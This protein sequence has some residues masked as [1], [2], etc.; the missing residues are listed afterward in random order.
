M[1]SVQQHYE[2]HLAP[3]YLW[4]AGGLEHAFALGSADMAPFLDRPGLAVDLGAGFGMHSLPLAR[5]GFRVL[6]IDTSHHLLRELQ[7]HAAGLPVQAVE[8]DLLDFAAH[9]CGPAE[10]VLCMG[11]TLTHLHSPAQVAQ[12]LHTVA[13]AL[14]PGGR[15]VATFRDYHQLPKGD[16]RFIAV[17]SDALRIH[18]CFLEEQ[19]DRVQVHD[20]LHERSSE[21]VPW[22]MR[23]SSY[24][25]LRLCP[26]SMAAAARGAGLRCQ[27][28]PG[29][30]GMLQLVA[31]A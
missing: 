17:R 30:R 22:Q 2:S 20:V 4:M 25:K 5:A 26:E 24:P 6:A 13:G 10:L 29:P 7:Q 3:I 12:L 18:I 28:G 9:L 14:A 27:V 8:A 19:G 15:F 31:Q 23:V 1:V 11:D 21:D 16:A